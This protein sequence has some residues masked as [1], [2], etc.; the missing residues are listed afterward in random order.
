MESSVITLSETDSVVS[1]TFMKVKFI[2]AQKQLKTVL[3]KSFSTCGIGYSLKPF[4]SVKHKGLV[5]MKYFTSAAK[6]NA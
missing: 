4:A 2:P 6:C 5:N 1:S 3:K